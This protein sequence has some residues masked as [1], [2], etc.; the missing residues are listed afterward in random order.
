MSALAERGEEIM[1]LDGKTMRRAL[2]RADGKGPMQ[3][4]SA[5]ASRNE[6]VLAQ[7]KVDANSHEITALPD[8]VSMLSLEGSVVTI[9]ARGC[10]GEIAGQIIDQGADYVLS[11]Q[12]NPPGVY[13][14]GVEL[15]AWR[16][17]P[18]ASDEEIV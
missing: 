10:H 18:H 8:L 17:G 2:A 7:G 4:G 15:F 13:D 1:A 3:V 16:K 14:D 9:D 5:W 12:E 11:L 6:L